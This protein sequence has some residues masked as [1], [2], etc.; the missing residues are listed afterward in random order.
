[1]I[2]YMSVSAICSL[3]ALG[4]SSAQEDGSNGPVDPAPS[5]EKFLEYGVHVPEDAVVTARPEPFNAEKHVIAANPLP[6]LNRAADPDVPQEFLLRRQARLQEPMAP[7]GNGDRGFFITGTAGWSIYARNDLQNNVSIPNSSVGT[8][9]YAPTHMSPGGF[10]GGACI[11]TVMAHWRPNAQ[12]ATLHGHGF[13]DWC[14]QSP[15]WG[16]FENIDATWISNY[17]R[18]DGAENMYFTEV[19]FTGGDCWVGQLWNY[20]TGVWDTKLTSCGSNKS[21]FGVTG[22]TMWESWNLIG[23]PTFPSIKATN[24]QIFNGAWVNLAPAHTTTLGPSAG[25]CF[26]SG[27]YNFHV[28]TANS[29]WHAHTP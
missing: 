6:E 11:E 23:C 14:R 5:E 28:H 10:G 2:K 19:V 7:P 1:M 17:A 27:T 9:M 24:L 15:G 12:S 18:S 25:S 22:W 8:T 16:V 21:G 13:W 4:C 3:A 26:A 20:N 29:Y